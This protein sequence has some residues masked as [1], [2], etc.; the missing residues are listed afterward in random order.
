MKLVAVI[1]LSILLV[2]VGVQI[3]TFIKEGGQANQSF[4]ELQGK[5]NQAKADQ[6]KSQ[7]ELNY[8]SN[9]NNLEK[10]LRARFNYK[11]PDEKVIILVPGA[12]LSASSTP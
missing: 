1:A 6:A 12:P 10:E 4:L 7:E 3:Y 5:L 11:S 8:Y 9:P 2:V